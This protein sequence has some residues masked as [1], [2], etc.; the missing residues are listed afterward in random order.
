MKPFTVQPE[1]LGK[2]AKCQS[3][4]QELR[5]FPQAFFSSWMHFDTFGY[6]HASLV[7]K[8]L[9]ENLFFFLNKDNE[10]YWYVTFKPLIKLNSLLLIR[11]TGWTLC[12]VPT[13]FPLIDEPWSI[14]AAASLRR[15]TRSRRRRRRRKGRR[16]KSAPGSGDLAG[17][18]APPHPPPP[19]PHP[20]T[21][22]TMLNYTHT[23]QQIPHHSSND[24]L[25]SCWAF[26]F[27]RDRNPRAE[28]QRERSQGFT[29][30]TSHTPL[31]LSLSQK[32]AC[33]IVH[34]RQKMS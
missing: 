15:R 29:S 26:G 6:L 16:W 33:N 8:E 3:S 21:T 34:Q 18:S 4:N 14:P 10:S 22:P 31:A 13:L 2:G 32:K 27:W 9:I 12:F 23:S 11:R 20:P 30:V 5:E 17:S 24:S 19:P 28:L 25:F 1:L 7:K